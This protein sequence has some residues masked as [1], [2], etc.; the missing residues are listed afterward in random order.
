MLWDFR[1]WEIEEESEKDGW[2]EEDGDERAS[3]DG[4]GWTTLDLTST[5]LPHSTI[6][7]L[8]LPLHTTPPT[9]TPIVSLSLAFAAPHLNLSTILPTT[10]PAHLRVLSLAGIRLF[11]VG[12]SS[13]SFPTL[14]IL[15]KLALAT[16]LLQV[17]IFPARTP[18][19]VPPSS[20][21]ESTTD[22]LSLSIF[23]STSISHGHLL[24]SSRWRSLF[25]LGQ[26]G[27]NAGRC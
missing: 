26:E 5:C 24:H 21:P 25:Y 8:L 3:E 18:L 22:F 9:P 11:P 15:R 19:R 1:K 17:S 20:S 10:L 2:E 12:S 23:N 27:K 4:E 16:P 13:S 6:K 14:S 7:Q